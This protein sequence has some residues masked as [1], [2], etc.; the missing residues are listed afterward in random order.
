MITQITM[1]MP[2]KEEELKELIKE[3]NVDIEKITTLSDDGKSLLT[4]IPTEIV[5]FL[6]LNK[7]NK[8]KWLINSKTKE[9]K[10]EIADVSKKKDNNR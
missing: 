7:G 2:I 8:F 4:R 10:L 9:I 3:P 1:N 6:K 5:S